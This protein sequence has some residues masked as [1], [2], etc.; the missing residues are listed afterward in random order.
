MHLI[1]E[2]DDD[3]IIEDNGLAKLVIKWKKRFN[4]IKDINIIE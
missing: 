2:E 4:N 1:E 3:T